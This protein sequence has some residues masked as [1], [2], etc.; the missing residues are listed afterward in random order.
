VAEVASLRLS[1]LKAKSRGKVRGSHLKPQGLEI[2][3]QMVANYPFKHF[4][5]GHGHW[6]GSRE[7]SQETLDFTMNMF[8][9]L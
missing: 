5:H 6:I 8:Q 4:Q 1:A 7:N 2:G 3:H 9:W